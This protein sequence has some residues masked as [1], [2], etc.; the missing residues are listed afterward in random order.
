MEPF[1][2]YQ[3]MGMGSRTVTCV[4]PQ[5]ASA[6]LYGYN[7]RCLRLRT[8]WT[9]GLTPKALLQMVPASPVGAGYWSPVYPQMGVEYW[10][11]PFYPP[12]MS[13]QVG[14]PPPVSDFHPACVVLVAG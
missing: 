12:N 9:E 1:A 6:T 11:R 7:L 13:P 3:L 14:I 2:P 10:G 4:C 5:G 8:S